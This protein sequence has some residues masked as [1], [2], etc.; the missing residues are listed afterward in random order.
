MHKRKQPTILYTIDDEDAICTTSYVLRVSYTKVKGYPATWG[1]NGGCPGEPSHV[2]D[3]TI[4]A[5]EEMQIGKQVVRDVHPSILDEIRER[6]DGC[7]AI[8]EACHAD[9]FSER[10]YDRD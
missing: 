5:V 7:E 6:Y 2:E 8:E 10:D 1:Y 9:A 4:E 3:V